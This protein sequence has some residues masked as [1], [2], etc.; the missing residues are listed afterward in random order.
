MIIGLTE[1]IL[2]SSASLCFIGFN[3]GAFAA[4]GFLGAAG[5]F[6]GAEGLA[7]GVHFFPVVL[8]VAFAEGFGCFEGF[9]LLP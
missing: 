4:V 2:F 8:P 7:A 3:L 5:V 1:P 6:F 9:P